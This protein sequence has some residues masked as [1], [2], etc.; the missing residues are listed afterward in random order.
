MR[1]LLRGLGLLVS[2]A[3]LAW[4]GLRF[5]QSDAFSVLERIEVGA[6]Q[7]G[8]ALAASATAYA[9]ALGLLAFAWWRL[10]A[11]LSPQQPPK[12]ATLATWCV[13]QYGK[14]LPGNVAHYALRHA[15]SRR[16]ATSHTV[17]GLAALI[18]AALLLLAALTLALCFGASG[19]RLP[20]VDLRLALGL[21]LAGSAVGAAV[22]Y[23]L[24]RHDRFAHLS[25]PTLPTNAIA[26]A[27]TCD[28]VFFA[29][30]ATILYGLG[31]LLGAD[32]G[33]SLMLAAGAASWAA[34][35]IVIGAPAGLGVREVAF[36][37]LAGGALGEERALLL[38]ALYRLVTFFGD[39]LAF[40]V[41]ALVMRRARATEFDG[42]SL[43][44]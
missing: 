39:T 12:G 15:W 16:H 37:A 18:E 41:G 23:G 40:T 2:L 35:F 30:T 4:I 24:R 33:W 21:V 11:G 32:A 17:L 5:V 26:S 10:L 3:A 28:L 42:D 13:S 8:A 7:L 29:A 25:L 34:G 22:L 9:L 14:Y 1:R 44:P 38:I 20:G 6:W 19:L 27:F 31:H 36:V 43:S